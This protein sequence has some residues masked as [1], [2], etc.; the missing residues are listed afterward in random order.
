MGPLLTT[1]ELA[2]DV[3]TRLLDQ[4]ALDE[5]AL[6]ALG[7]DDPRYRSEVVR[8]ERKLGVRRFVKSVPYIGPFMRAVYQRVQRSRRFER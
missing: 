8:F 7:G 6:V 2:H 3:R 1:E 5:A 4:C